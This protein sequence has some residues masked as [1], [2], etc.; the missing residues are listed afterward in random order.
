[1]KSCCVTIFLSVLLTAAQV[2]SVSISPAGQVVTAGSATNPT[3]RE[4]K[5][6]TAGAP[7]IGY[8]LG[9]EPA[10][11]HAILTIAKVPQLGELITPP[12]NSKRVYV[13]PRQEYAIVERNS[14][15]PVA[16][17]ALHREVTRG[18]KQELVTIKGAMARP[19]FVT[20]SPRGD[21]LVLYSQAAGSLQVVSALPAQPAVTTQL[22]IPNP[23]TPFRI[24]VSDDGSLVAAGLVNGRLVSSWNGAAWR[25]LPPGLIPQAWLFLPKTHNLA[26]SD[27]AQKTIVLLPDV[28]DGSKA[29]RILAQQVQADHL[30][31]TKD[32]E[33]LVAA[34]LDEG[35]VWSIDLKTGTIAQSDEIARVEGLTALRDGFTFLLSTTPGLSVMRLS[36]VRELSDQANHART[37]GLAQTVIGVHQ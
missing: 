3:A 16:V 21:A 9:P 19:D 8:V 14:D 10:A 27:I 29:S 13:P 30:A 17:W 26:I 32:G 12:D 33:Q 25:S 2:P 31:A 34:N 37:A 5:I 24:A 4:K 11:L 35:R 15:D 1:M 6:G 28:E 23:G 22:S 18:L 36:A 7:V 20:F